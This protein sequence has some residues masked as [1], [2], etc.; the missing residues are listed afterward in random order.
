MHLT[1]RK[2][3][4]LVAIADAG[5]VSAA[6]D[7]LGLTQPALSRNIADIE[8]FFGARIFERGRNGAKPTR[9]GG[10][11]ISNARRLLAQASR[12]ESEFHDFAAGEK[13]SVRIGLAPLPASF[14]LPGMMIPAAQN[15]GHLQVDCIVDGAER[16]LASLGDGLLDI[17]VCP[18]QLVPAKPS[19]ATSR[20]CFVKLGLF[21]RRDHPLSE[22][23]NL[24][25][26]DCLSFPVAT[27]PGGGVDDSPFA[28]I[29]GGL[30]P[31]IRFPDFA[32]L[33]RLMRSTDAILVGTAG[34]LATDIEQGLAIELKISDLELP[35]TVEFQIVTLSGRF[36]SNA[37]TYLIELMRSE[38]GRVQ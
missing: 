2:L 7:R 25:I 18:R 8:D 9:T 24:T 11:L 13:G 32:G 23:S 22:R 36:R 15:R 21:V 27:G 34:L 4:Q 31:T 26:S 19:L 30:V 1:F 3:E 28:P 14:L 20:L 33:A 38:A 29:L 35:D 16:L 37:E 10:Y 17:V 6:A 12:L 5:T